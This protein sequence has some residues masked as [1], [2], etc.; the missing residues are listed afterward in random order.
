LGM[1]R[2]EVSFPSCTLVITH[3]LWL[4]FTLLQYIVF[5]V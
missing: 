2:G 1:R 4:M 3:I 5:P